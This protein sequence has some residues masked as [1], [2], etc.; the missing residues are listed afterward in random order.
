MHEAGVTVSWYDGVLHVTGELD[1]DSCPV[2]R[3]AI[4]A[5]LVGGNRR[6]TLELSGVSFC[7]SS[8]VHCLVDPCRDGVEV[9]VRR[10]SKAVR[11]VLELLGVVDLLTVED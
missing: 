1:L 9:V 6:I 8:C 3:R 7:D 10:P 4:Q 11:R 5:H 2:L